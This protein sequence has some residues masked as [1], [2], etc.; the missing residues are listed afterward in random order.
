MA[1][2]DRGGEE[3]APHLALQRIYLKDV[4]FES[5]RAPEVFRETWSPKVQLDLNNRAERIE[6]SLYEVV[7]TLTL[8][9][10]DEQDRACYIVEIQQAGMFRVENLEGEQ[11]R[12]TLSSYCPSV[13]FPYARET[14][15]A[16]VV[17]GS[18]PALML[19][20]VNFDALYL[21]ARRRAD[22]AVSH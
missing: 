17:R 11:L 20:P 5:P 14:V 6:E 19:A 2:S 22:D 8:E 9:A 12:H 1:E 4:S 15:D 13:L 21:E 3:A 7:L 18:F 16:L 10:R